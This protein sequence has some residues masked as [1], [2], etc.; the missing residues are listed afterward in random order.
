MD[1][2]CDD[3]PSNREAAEETDQSLTSSVSSLCQL[4]D[5][6][7]GPIADLL[8]GDQLLLVPDGPDGTLRV[9]QPGFALFPR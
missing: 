5:V 8:E 6:I 9:K 7:I 4:Y 2:I 1:E 3:T